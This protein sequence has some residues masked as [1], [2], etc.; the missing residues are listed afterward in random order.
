MKLSDKIKLFLYA[1]NSPVLKQDRN[2]SYKFA[3]E[4]AKKAKNENKMFW[5]CSCFPGGLNMKNYPELYIL[6]P[7][8]VHSGGCWWNA[9]DYSSRINA[10]EKAIKLIS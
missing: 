6:K 4:S 9:Y 1:I 7:K 8:K 2:N 5:M 3:L 10:I